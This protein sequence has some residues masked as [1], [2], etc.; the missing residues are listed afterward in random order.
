MNKIAV[1]I[2]SEN[3]TNLFGGEAILALRYFELLKTHEN[4]EPYL[5]THCRNRSELAKIS[6]L[7]HDKIYYIP[8]TW[9]FRFLQ[10]LGRYIPKTLDIVSYGLLISLL[11]SISQ[12]WIARKIIRKHQINL[13]HQ[14]SP[15]S[16]KIPSMMFG[17]KRPVII[18]P[19]NGGMDYPPAFKHMNTAIESVSYFIFR[20]FS[21]V[22]NV[23]IPG[24]FLANLLLVS[25]IR[26]QNALPKFHAKRVEVL[27]ENGVLVTKKILRDPIKKNIELLFV[28]RLVDW[29]GLDILLEALNKCVGLNITLTVIGDGPEENHLKGYSN[30]L[31]LSNVAFVGHIPFPL[32]TKYYDSADIF[33]LPSLRECGGAVVLEAMARG[34]P[35]IATD[36][37]GPADYVTKETGFLIKPTSRE[38][39]VK[40]ISTCIAALSENQ[41]LREKMGSAALKHVN[42]NFLW[43]DKIIQMTNYYQEVLANHAAGTHD[44]I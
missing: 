32:L 28:G 26:T 38:N 42:E 17:L 22:A 11:T 12:W 27:V 3:A 30:Q 33:V 31:G 1:L 39:M 20:S 5:L 19:M 6:H 21:H 34:L 40:E 44:L 43:H 4:V 24:K 2:V 18:G 25:N 36:W 15:V 16:P 29:K 9:L 37:G 14:P 23:I 10:K 7:D 8:D 41:S 13:I 35:V